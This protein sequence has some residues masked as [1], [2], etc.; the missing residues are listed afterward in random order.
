MYLATHSTQRLSIRP[1]TLA[2]QKAW[3]PFFVQNESLR[4]FD[5]DPELSPEQKAELWINWQLD[6]YAQNRFGLLGLVSKENNTLIGMCGFLT[7][8]ING[9][10]EI[11]I[12]YHVLPAYWGKGFATE[13]AQYFKNY[14]WQQKLT[15]SL[16]SI[17]HVDNIRSQRVAGKNGMLQTIK[18]EFRGKPVYIY[19]ISAA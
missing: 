16:I 11:E 19:R 6:R 13:A 3:A 4:F 5:L 7:Q 8:E 10:T 18:T 17:I 15:D 12:G 1:L 2:D 14:A 9:Q